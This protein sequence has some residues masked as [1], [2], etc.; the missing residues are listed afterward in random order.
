MFQGETNFPVGTPVS[1]D[2]AGYIQRGAGFGI[3]RNVSYSPNDIMISLRT[4]VLN[5]ELLVAA[6][7]GK[8]HCYLINSDGEVEKEQTVLLFFA[9]NVV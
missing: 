8:L 3:Y 9:L 6:Y 4:E 1:L 7:I 5:G 2:F